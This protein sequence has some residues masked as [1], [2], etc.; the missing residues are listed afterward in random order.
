MRRAARAFTLL[1]MM[2]TLAIVAVLGAIALPMYGQHVV[3]SAV[4]EGT[5]RLAE[6][7]V[8][9]EQWYLDR[10]TYEGACADGAKVLPSSVKNWAFTCEASAAAYTI[11][12]KGSGRASGFE[13]TVDQTDARKT[14]AAPDGW[15]TCGVKWLTRKGEACA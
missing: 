9:M 2:V 6:A 14:V 4:A 12:A 10:R 13:Y 8:K 5:S 1:E 7:R 11:T 15:G 3:R